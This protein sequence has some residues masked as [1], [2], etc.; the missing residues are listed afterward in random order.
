MADLTPEQIAAQLEQYTKVLDDLKQQQGGLSESSQVSIAKIKTFV[1]EL[2]TANTKLTEITEKLKAAKATAQTGMDVDKANVERL[3]LQLEKQR[4]LA[5]QYN[6]NA[7]AV[8]NLAKKTSQ[9]FDRL[10]ADQ[11]KQFK[12][13]RRNQ[14]ATVGNVVAQGKSL[15]DGIA[16]TGPA[17]DALRET[18]KGLP[19]EAQAGVA[20]GAVFGGLDPVLASILKVQKLPMIL[21]DVQAAFNKSTFQVDN[22]ASSFLPA[23]SNQDVFEQKYGDF[24]AELEESGGLFGSGVLTT[25]QYQSALMAVTEGTARFSANLQRQNKGQ[26]AALTSLVALLQRTGVEASDTIG[27]FNTLNSGLDMNVGDVVQFKQELVGL[28]RSLGIGNRIFKGAAATLDNLQGFSNNAGESFKRLAIE[29]AAAGMSTDEV[30]NFAASFD[31]FD[32]AARSVQGLNAVLGET[33]FD[34]TEIQQTPIEDRL[35]LIRDRLQE[36]GISFNDLSFRQRRAFAEFM[37]G[38]KSVAELGKLLSQN[39]AELTERQLALADSTAISADSLADQV[40]AAKTAG[41]ALAEGPQALALGLDPSPLTDAVRTGLLE[42]EKGIRELVLGEGGKLG[43]LDPVARIA[44]I[45]TATA[46]LAQVLKSLGQGEFVKAGSIAGFLELLRR[47]ST[48]ENIQKAKDEFINIFD[49]VTAAGTKPA[50]PGAAPVAPPQA[51]S[52]APGNTT[53]QVNSSKMEQTRAI[54]APEKQLA[55]VTL[56]HTTVLDGDV[57]EKSVKKLTP[58]VEQ[59]QGGLDRRY[60]Q[61]MPRMG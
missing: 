34:F 43:D 6:S 58:T 48:I 28:G 4:E 31:D 21:G 16:N 46:G 41:E 15:L 59:L 44:A 11:E 26:T 24:A 13:A 8:D 10:N 19:T 23:I 29:A 36:A 55:Q 53:S 17:L 50:S 52:P 45:T 57:V 39:T 54:N 32:T 38:G 5:A 42:T 30:A 27:I 18:I 56:N 2:V 60:K 49:E 61:K 25:E 51:Q 37:P 33:V 9:A 7:A 1:D 22:F 3:N 20:F 12:N 35:Q 40:M 47:P 14:Q